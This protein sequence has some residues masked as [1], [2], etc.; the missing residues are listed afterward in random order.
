M[1]FVNMNESGIDLDFD[2]VA[3]LCAEG[4]DIVYGE[5]LQDEPM[6]IVNTNTRQ[7]YMFYELKSK[8]IPER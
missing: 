7:D 1:N 8:T 6:D 4:L 2:L 5:S 3:E